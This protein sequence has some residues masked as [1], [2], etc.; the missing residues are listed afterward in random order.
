LIAKIRKFVIAST[1]AEELTQQ[2]VEHQQYDYWQLQPR[3]LSAEQ[4]QLYHPSSQPITI[5]IGEWL[6]TRYLHYFV[7]YSHLAGCWYCTNLTH[8]TS[9]WYNYSMKLTLNFSLSIPPLSN[10]VLL[11]INGRIRHHH[12]GCLHRGKKGTCADPIQWQG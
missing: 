4:H 1:T 2:L 3:H 9:H 12:D 5:G 11:S 7:T 6:Q 10:N 8:T